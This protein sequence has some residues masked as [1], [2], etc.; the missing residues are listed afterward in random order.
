MNFEPSTELQAKINDRQATEFG[1]AAFHGFALET[2]AAAFYDDN[3]A[4]TQQIEMMA[5]VN[6]E[7]MGKIDELRKER[8]Q[9]RE[10]RD[11]LASQL[12]LRNSRQSR[13]KPK[14]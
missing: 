9:L 10:E 1:K 3:T 13:G 14:T 6:T 2:V 12:S 7:L 11:S 8:D 5:A 4:K